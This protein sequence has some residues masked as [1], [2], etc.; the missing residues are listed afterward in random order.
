MDT[1]TLTFV[2]FTTRITVPFPCE[3]ES[4]LVAQGSPPGLLLTGAAVEVSV[5]F[6]VGSGNGVS[7]G[8]GVCVDASVGG[9]GVAVGTAA[10]V[11]ATIVKAAATAVFWT[12][13]PFIV[14]AARVPHALSIRARMAAV[15]IERRFM[16]C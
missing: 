4:T 14:G 9:R 16:L 11:C 10:R 13:T 6:K 7:V 8:R 5:T 1:V 2:V 3:G 15:R 12:S